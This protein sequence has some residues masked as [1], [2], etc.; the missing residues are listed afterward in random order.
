MTEKAKT[1]TSCGLEQ[2]KAETKEIQNDDSK[3]KMKV[4]H[5]H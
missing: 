5:T 2:K 1:V 3:R 4:Q